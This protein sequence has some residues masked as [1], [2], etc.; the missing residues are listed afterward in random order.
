MHKEPTNEYYAIAVNADNTYPPTRASH[1]KDGV[2]HPE[3][4]DG[5]L[6]TGHVIVDGHIIPCGAPTPPVPPQSGSL[7]EL[8]YIWGD[9]EPY[10]WGQTE[11]YFTW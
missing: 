10:T 6:T 4:Q 1:M 11:E 5:F 8:G 2:P 9:L 7:Y 3:I